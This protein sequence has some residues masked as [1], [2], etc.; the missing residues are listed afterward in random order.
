[1]K[2]IIGN[3]INLIFKDSDKVVSGVLIETDER[4]DYIQSNQVLCVI[5]KDNVLYYETDKMPPESK[6]ITNTASEAR[7]NIYIDKQFVSAVSTDLKGTELVKAIYGIE[8]VQ[9]NLQGKKQKSVE[10]FDDAVYI[11]T[12]AEVEVAKPESPIAFSLQAGG[13]SNPYVSQVDLAA[14]LDKVIKRG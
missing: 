9:E 8:E 13:G 10:C 12:D 14:R 7:I 11:F 4:F 2:N 3:Q 5:P 1:M 6:V